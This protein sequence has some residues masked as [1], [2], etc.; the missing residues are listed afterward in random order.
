V[1]LNGS[2]WKGCKLTVAPAKPDYR[3]RLAAEATESSAKDCTESSQTPEAGMHV[4]Q[5]I[6]VR[7]PNKTSFKLILGSVTGSQRKMF[8]PNPEKPLKEIYRDV[9]AVQS[10]HSSSLH[11]V[12]RVWDDVAERRMHCAAPDFAV[13][14]TLRHNVTVRRCKSASRASTRSQ[15][16]VLTSPCNCDCERV[17]EIFVDSEVLV[18]CSMHTNSGMH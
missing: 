10:Q 9:L 12:N 7:L 4:P 3:E 2:T 13:F 16:T 14:A 6:T 17:I 18:C 5:A 11:H 1:Q 15:R 8:R